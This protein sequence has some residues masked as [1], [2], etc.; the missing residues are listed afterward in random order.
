MTRKWINV[1]G[2]VVVACCAVI[3]GVLCEV[4]QTGRMRVLLEEVRAFNQA[5]SIFTDS[6]DA[7]TLVDYYC[8]PLR[9]WVSA[10]DRLLAH[11]LLGRAYADMGETP[12]AIEEYCE[13]VEQVDTATADCDLLILRAVYGQM[14][15]VFHQQNLPQDEIRANS[16]YTAISHIMKDTLQMGIGLENLTR[17]YYLMG[18]TS[19]L[20]RAAEAAA[21]VFYSIGRRDK[22]ANALSDIVFIYIQRGQ[23][24]KAMELIDTIYAES[25]LFD[26][27]GQ[28]RRGN[29]M[30]YYTIGLFFDSTNQLDSAEYY[31]R[32]LIPAHKLEAAY[33]GLLS[34]YQKREIPDSIGK[35]AR[36]YADANDAMHNEMRT[37]AVA[38]AAKSY[39]YTRQQRLAQQYEAKAKR[40][41]YGLC[42][43]LALILVLSYIIYG[44]RIKVQKKTAALAYVKEQYR[45]ALND[46]HKMYAD[47]AAMETRLRSIDA[48]TAY[49]SSDIINRVIDAVFNIND[50]SAKEL[51]NL[52]NLFLS[53]FNDFKIFAESKGGLTENEWDVCIYVDLG[54]RDKDICNLMGISAQRV[55]GLKRQLNRKLFLSDEGTTLARN[56]RKA[57]HSSNRT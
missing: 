49:Y 36:L 37:Q 4:R 24:T 10:N 44:Q 31:Y 6:R 57:L 56:L 13:A 38:Q 47:K 18:D 27:Q 9:I 21:D 5:D 30:F 20:L 48:H 26:E 17:P 23:Y 8:E 35:F 43:F 32:K 40:R 55:Q 41:A 33:R 42:V 52:Y 19:N 25:S 54:F 29:E 53:T 45:K 16:N 28:L 51:N 15:N 34:V 22:A 3:F 1:I 7:R 11:Y 2:I 39:Q 50:V 46:Y 12:R 14:A